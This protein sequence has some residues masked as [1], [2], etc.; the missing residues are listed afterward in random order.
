MS[1]VDENKLEAAKS[2]HY[3]YV[4]HAMD[5]ERQ[6]QFTIYR[7]YSLERMLGGFNNVLT[8]E[9]KLPI[10]IDIPD[11]LDQLYNLDIP[12]YVRLS[13]DGS[14]ESFKSLMDINPYLFNYGFQIQKV[15]RPMTGKVIQFFE[16]EIVEPF[17]Y[18]YK[19]DNP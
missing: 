17:N 4:T 18:N 2:N 1:I 3:G 14:I 13:D 15:I 11:E 16:R 10:S 12:K 8:E 6:Q 5:V 19:F 9:P 7:G